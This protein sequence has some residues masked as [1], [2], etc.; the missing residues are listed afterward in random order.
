MSRL[1]TFGCS[2]T[3][4][5]GLPDCRN[6]LFDKLHSLQQVKWVGRHCWQKN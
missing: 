4:G 6:W 2:Y 3:Y 1:I 5:T